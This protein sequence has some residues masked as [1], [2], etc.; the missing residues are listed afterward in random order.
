M[1]PGYSPFNPYGVHPYAPPGPSYLHP[2]PLPN[3]TP[4]TS[5]NHSSATSSR[6][7]PPLPSSDGPLGPPLENF[8]L[9][10]SWLENLENSA[11][12]NPGSSVYYTLHTSNLEKEGIRNLSDLYAEV[13]DHEAALLHGLKI[14]VGDVRR[15]MKFAKQDYKAIFK[16]WQKGL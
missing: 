7:A 6:H 11:E 12:R 1:A 13:V 8:P 15:I 3:H 9:I 14:P 4:V 10:D 5:E 16:A 2:Q